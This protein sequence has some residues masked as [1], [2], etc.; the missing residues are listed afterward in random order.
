MCH[1]FFIYMMISILL[2]L[3]FF[4]LCENCP[5]EKSWQLIIISMPLRIQQKCIT[6]YD[7]APLQILLLFLVSFLHKVLNL[8]ISYIAK[9]YKID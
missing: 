4:Y 8:L 6:I 5:F 1:F 9:M 7:M 2:I 3:K